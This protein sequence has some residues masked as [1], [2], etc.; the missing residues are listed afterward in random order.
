MDTST[1]SAPLQRDTCMSPMVISIICE[2]SMCGAAS[3]E[4]TS[5]GGWTSGTMST[6]TTSCFGMVR[7]YMSSA[8]LSGMENE[9]PRSRLT[10]EKKVDGLM[11][12]N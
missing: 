4:I 8:V 10:A 2:L 5:L 6:L 1:G 12:C 11:S 9:F 3:G 7:S